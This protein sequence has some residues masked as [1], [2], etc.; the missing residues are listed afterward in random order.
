MV[1]RTV[2]GWRK[3]GASH[4]D[5]CLMSL[6]VKPE[7]NPSFIHQIHVI[8]KKLY[9]CGIRKSD[10]GLP[11]AIGHPLPVLAVMN[12]RICITVLP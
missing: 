7:H 3:C 6:N 12:E 9:L 1:W 8:Y 2:W 10:E 4:D 11:C 5:L